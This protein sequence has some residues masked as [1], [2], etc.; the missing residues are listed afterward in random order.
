MSGFLPFWG[1]IL[2][3]ILSPFAVF[4]LLNRVCGGEATRSPQ[5]F[6][7]CMGLG[8]LLLSWG[9]LGLLAAAPGKPHSFHL[10]II[11]GAVF[12]IIALS[13]RSSLECAKNR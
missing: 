13:E 10:W 9:L 5:S 12:F 8:P 3:Y 4:A 1:I 11:S 7:A 2:A 6:F